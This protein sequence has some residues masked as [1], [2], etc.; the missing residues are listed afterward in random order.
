M[1]SPRNNKELKLNKFFTDV[2]ETVINSIYK[3]ENFKEVNEGDVIYKAGETSE[4][5]YL[6][7]RGDVKIKFPSHNYISNK[8][9][10]EFFGEKELFDKT[11]R[12][13]S[14]VANNKCLLYR[15]Q[16]H[17]F[18]TL[19]SKSKTIKKNIETFGEIKIPEVNT[20]TKSR[21]DLAKSIKPRLFR[22][23]R[24]R[25]EEETDDE[26]QVATEDLSEID[27]SNI[28]IDD[29]SVEL[30]N[31]IIVE[32][33]KPEAE[34]PKQEKESEAF[35][36]VHSLLIEEETAKQEYFDSANTQNFLDMLSSINQHYKIYDTIRSIVNEFQKLTSSGA[37]EIYLIDKQSTELKKL[38]D[39]NGTI[40]SVKFENSEGLTGTCALQGMTINLENPFEDSRF[41]DDIDR[42]G[43]SKLNKI[44]YLPLLG[45]NKETVG[46]LQLARINK[47]YSDKDIEHLELFSKYAAIAI[48]RCNSIEKLIELEK[49]ISN[50][51]I[52]KFLTESLLIPINVINSYTSHLSKDS[53]SQKIREMIALIKNQTNFIWDIFESVF[54]YNKNDFKL[55]FERVNINDY[56]NR[57]TELLSDYCSSRKINL[58]KKTGDDKEVN[59]D[60][61]KLFMAA[62]QLIENACNV[63]SEGG[64]VFISSDTDEGYVQISVMDEGPGISDELQ[65]SIFERGVSTGKGRSN[66]GL[67]IAKRIVELHSGYL[68]FSSKANVGSTF[69]IRIPV[70]K[71]TGK[72]Q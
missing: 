25:E 6:L 39:E 36:K 43:D 57:I 1:S 11:R 18:E 71:N 64:K 12:N 49:Q 21:I 9:F 14:A 17:I 3:P 8:V 53:F 40:S 42:P 19:I 33:N 26:G 50:D 22:A 54:Y 62:F 61:G 52:E 46:V 32:E 31:Q 7:L 55:N 2:N 68:S 41:V 23:I 65:E 58:F 27:N 63:T 34:I 45:Q 10:N 29:S 35:E 59:I 48:E 16:K 4:E 38:V 24:S 47:T 69:T 30:E 72:S 51:S 13:S 5:L 70:V 28:Q 60:S 56:I 67:P 20:A 66:F 37:G 44:I 15:V